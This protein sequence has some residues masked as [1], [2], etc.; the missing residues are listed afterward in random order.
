MF[1]ENILNNLDDHTLGLD[2]DIG[3]HI[4]LTFFGNLVPI[5]KMT[6]EHI[7]ASDSGLFD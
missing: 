6:H 2:I 1:G 5:L 7:T 4:I 3:H